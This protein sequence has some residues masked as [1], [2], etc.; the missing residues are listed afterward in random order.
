MSKLVIATHNPAKIGE[1]SKYLA[2]LVSEGVELV[3]LADLGI[4]EEPEETGTTLEENAILKAKYYAE[5][6]N[7]PCLADDGGFEIDIL[8]GEPGVKSNRWLGY[9]ATD[10]ELI[11]YTLKRLEGI[12]F[13]QRAARGALVLA[14]FN[15]ATQTLATVKQG[16]EG[17]MAETTSGHVIPGFPYRALFKVKAYGNKYYDELTEEEHDA[18]NHRRKAVLEITPEIRTDLIQ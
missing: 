16:I 9:K 6:T 1:L 11:D 18:V 7:L 17:Y 4:T 15:P 2:P 3:S 8:N 10:Q 14:Y 5:K 12:P 13:D